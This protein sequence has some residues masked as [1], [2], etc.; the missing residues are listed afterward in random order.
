M[1]FTLIFYPQVPPLESDRGILTP[2]SLSGR[3]QKQLLRSKTVGST[4][5]S[6]LVVIIL[7]IL[8]YKKIINYWNIV[9]T[10]YPWG[11]L[12]NRHKKSHHEEIH[13]TVIVNV[14]PDLI[15][16][17]V[18]YKNFTI[19]WLPKQLICWMIIICKHHQFTFIVGDTSP[20]QKNTCKL[21]Q[22][23]SSIFDHLNYFICFSRSQT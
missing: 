10:I 2:L 6:S 23:N 5:Y 3:F 15:C 22:I 19:I 1:L 14:L 7:L 11:Y 8:E 17:I 16:F 13:I 18:A 21:N 12:Q 4:Q 9:K 20:F